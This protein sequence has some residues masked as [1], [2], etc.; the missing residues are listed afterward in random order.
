MQCADTYTG[1]KQIGKDRQM[2]IR[3]LAAAAAAVGLALAVW[4]CSG[5]GG[6]DAADFKENCLILK[7][8]GALWWA[9]VE[10]AGQGNY[11]QEEML[12]FAREAISAYNASKGSESAADYKKGESLPVSVVSGTIESGRAVLVTAYDKPL[13]L[14][15]FSQEIGDS[16]MG[17]TELEAG[18]VEGLGLDFGSVDW[19]DTKGAAAAPEDVSKKGSALVLKTAGEGLVQTER[20][21]RY[22]SQGCELVSEHLVR[23]PSEGTGCIVTE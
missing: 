15:E 2:K 23:M 9:S 20:K 16:S 6:A 13:E 19:R 11:D 1:L 21:I 17:F 8:D 10:D 4:G 14:L 22:V 7:K 3:K 5:S 12:S 18:T